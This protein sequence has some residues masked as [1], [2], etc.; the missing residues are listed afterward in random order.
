MDNEITYNHHILTP[1]FRYILMETTLKL[2]ASHYY[3][4]IKH[5]CDENLL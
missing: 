5:G 4:L 1:L 2:S 3:Y